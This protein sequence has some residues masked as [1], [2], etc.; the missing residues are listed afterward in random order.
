MSDYELKRTNWLLERQNK[1]LESMMAQ[2]DMI[3]PPEPP[4]IKY[5]YTGPK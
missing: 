5:V 4:P 2:L 3:L 1:L